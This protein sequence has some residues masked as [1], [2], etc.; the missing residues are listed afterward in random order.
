MFGRKCPKC[1]SKRVAFVN[2]MG[3]KALMCGNCGYDETDVLAI[4]PGSRN[5]Q[6][7]K[8]SYNPFRSRT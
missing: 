5:T 2:Y 8:R 7:E 6:R 4:T 1:G 3:A